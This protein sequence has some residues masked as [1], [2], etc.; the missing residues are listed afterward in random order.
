MNI[1]LK[2]EYALRALQ[3]VIA[4]GKGK[5]ITR[6]Q[7]AKNQGISEHFLEK[8]FIDLQKN[9]II[10]SVRGPGGGF[11]LNREP[12]DITLWDVYHAVD[13]P[14]YREDRC[15]HKT[16]AG[17]EQREQCG[18]KNIWFKFSRSLK[19]CMVDITLVEITMKRRMMSDE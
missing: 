15:Y 4:A 12:H 11:I 10:K 13:D 3:E 16:T 18:V 2:T 9:R 19:E 8:I 5:P 1:T 17:C 6:R 7:I 14:D